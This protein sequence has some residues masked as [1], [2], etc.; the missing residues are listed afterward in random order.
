MNVKFWNGGEMKDTELTQ[1]NLMYIYMVNKMLDGRMKLRKMGIEESAI[2]DIEQHLDPRIVKMADWLQDEFL[3][4]TRNEY[5][6]TH[7]RIFGASMASVEHYFPL[8][9]LANARADK[10]EDLDNPDRTDGISTTTGSII[11]RRR[12]TLVLDITGADVLH[13]ILDHVA[14]MEHWNAY[15]EYNRDLNTLRT[16]KHFRNQVQ[17]MNTIYGSGKTL[18]NKFNDVCQMSTGSYRSQRSNFDAAATNFAK[19]VTAAKVSFRIFTALKQFLSAPAYIPEANPMYLAASIA[20]PWNSWNWCMKNLPI[21]KERWESRTSGDPRLLKSE[22]DWKAWRSSIIQIASRIGMSPNAFID[23]ITVS[24][25][26]YSMYETRRDRYLKYGYDNDRA[27]KKARQDSEVL[28]NQTQQSSEGPFTSTMQVDKSWL[29]VMFTVFRNSNMSYQRQLHDAIRNI[30]R[31]V[32]IQGYKEKSIDF[33][34]NQF[35]RDGLDEKHATSAANRKYK[36]HIIK[37]VLRV[38]TFG[39]IMQLAWNLVAY[40]PY[41]LFGNDED[42]KNK[43]WDDVWSHTAFGWM[44]GY[45][46]GDVI[47]SAGNMIFSGDGNPEYT[48]K[49]MPISSDISNIMQ[50]FGSKEYNEAVNDIVNLIVQSGIGVNPQSITDAALA[51]MDAC[52]DD[53]KLA[54]EATIFVM[55]VLQVPQ[56]QID[57]NSANMSCGTLLQFYRI[58][59]RLAR[60]R[61]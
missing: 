25:G 40:I 57:S 51:I 8:K 47:S 60:V 61:V 46:G 45:S 16:Y 52:G 10:P 48:T 36:N 21:F 28:Y 9:I 53:P 49:D 39:Y 38:A 41:I 13:V 20:Q 2:N 29:N 17:N 59:H 15:S 22:M 26:A 32:L 42:E 3:V 24:I 55:R 11:K 18:W 6:E 54:H 14:Q 1:G 30:K 12:N 31:N 27:E 7:K 34:T 35:V 33:M 5:N 50:K 43:M 19:G 37:D 56:G 44:E 58:R 23:A 4:G